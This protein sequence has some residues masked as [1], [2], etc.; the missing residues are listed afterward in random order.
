MSSKLPPGHGG[1]RAKPA[2]D[3]KAQPQAK[4]DPV[5]RRVPLPPPRPSKGGV[6]DAK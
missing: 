2:D 5:G 6:S 1:Y 3:G 4:N